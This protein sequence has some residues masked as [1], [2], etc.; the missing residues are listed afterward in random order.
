MLE[1][2]NHSECRDEQSL[3]IGHEC[4]LGCPCI[5]GALQ[6]WIERCRLTFAALDAVEAWAHREH[7]L[8]VRASSHSNNCR[9]VRR[10]ASTRTACQF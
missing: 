5:Q 9:A 4:R 8:S 1:V 7:H 6:E 10:S 3:P 2:Q